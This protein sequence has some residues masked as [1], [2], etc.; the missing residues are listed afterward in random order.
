MTANG[1]ELIKGLREFNPVG[2]Y[3]KPKPPLTL[4][5]QEESLTPSAE[6][7]VVEEAD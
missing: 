1:H 6:E 7:G 2:I 3:T 5:L 4:I